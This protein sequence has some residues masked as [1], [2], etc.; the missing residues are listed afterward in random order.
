MKTKTI[1]FV[2]GSILTLLA[3]GNLAYSFLSYEIIKNNVEITVH[4]DTSSTI[5][6]TSGIIIPNPTDLNSDTPKN[7][8]YFYTIDSSKHI[9]EI[10]PKNIT[11]E[12]VCVYYP[13]N[14][15]M[16]YPL[17]DNWDIYSP[18]NIVNAYPLPLPYM[19]LFPVEPTRDTGS[20]SNG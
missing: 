9:L 3:I 19:F 11:R 6:R 8:D 18:D 20:A 1:L 7:E 16:S 12:E 15:P 13:E 5:S 14:W 10:C 4:R 17:P 2:F